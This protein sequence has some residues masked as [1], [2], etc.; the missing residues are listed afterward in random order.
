ME[1]VKHPTRRSAHLAG[2]APMSLR[3]Q[4]Q[5]D[6]AGPMPSWLRLLRSRGEGKGD[7]G[8][9]NHAG[10]G[11]AFLE[12]TPLMSSTCLFNL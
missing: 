10:P 4:P 9:C 12:W 3:G 1:Q 11:E 8:F 7:P 6:H 2:G 5:R